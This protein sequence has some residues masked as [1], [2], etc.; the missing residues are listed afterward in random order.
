VTVL[1]SC[2]GD[3]SGASGQR[4]ALRWLT[5]SAGAGARAGRQDLDSLARRSEVEGALRGIV[6][7]RELDAG[8]MKRASLTDLQARQDLVRLHT[9]STIATTAT[10]YP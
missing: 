5:R 9:V 2:D 3:A 1:Q 8:K 4:L 6:R 7:I 10:L